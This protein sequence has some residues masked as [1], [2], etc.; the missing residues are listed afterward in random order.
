MKSVDPVSGMKEPSPAAIQAATAA[1]R[2]TLAH[3]KSDERGVAMP[4][5]LRAAYAI[6]I[7]ELERALRNVR[8]I[9]EAYAR[10]NHEDEARLTVA[11][12]DLAAAL[13]SRPT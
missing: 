3:Q 5:A 2:E 11:K 9:N 12:A 13:R 7:E 10:R 6:D 1:Y 8:K 4:A